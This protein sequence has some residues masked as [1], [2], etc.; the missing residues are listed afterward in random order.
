[1]G[2]EAEVVEPERR[3]LA[4]ADAPPER[5]R[6]LEEPLRGLVLAARPGD[7]AEAVERVADRPLVAALAR[8]RE[9]LLELRPRRP[10]VALREREDAGPEQRP[11]ARRRAPVRAGEQGGGP[12]AALLPVPADVPEAAEGGGEL[13]GG[14][15]PLRLR[16]APLRV[17]GS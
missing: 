4:V 3:A 2:D 11:R 17:S 8:D 9:A 12:A 6:L 16:F 14:L 1:L 13:E 10:E 15:R 7:P 5:Q